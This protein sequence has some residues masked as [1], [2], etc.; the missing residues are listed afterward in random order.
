MNLL[1]TALNYLKQV[2]G[3]GAYLRYCE[4]LRR[5]GRAAD[6]PTPREFYLESVRRCYSK[7][8]RCC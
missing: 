5:K 2:M 8:S 6:I 7:P 4:H 1:K 3:E